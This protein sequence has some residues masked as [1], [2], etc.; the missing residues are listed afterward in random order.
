MESLTVLESD[1]GNTPILDSSNIQVYTTESSQQYMDTID[2]DSDESQTTSTLLFDTSS[3][4]EGIS[5]NNSNN[6]D[7]ARQ[8][9]ALD[10]NEQLSEEKSIAVA[11]SE[12]ELIWKNSGS[13]GNDSLT[14]SPNV[15]FKAELVQNSS[16]GRT[17]LPPGFRTSE[18]AQF[19]PQFQWQ[20]NTTMSFANSKNED[21]FVETQQRLE[22][23]KA[24]V[25]EQFL[26]FQNLIDYQKAL[27]GRDPLSPVPQERFLMKTEE[28]ISERENSSDQEP[29]VEDNLFT[30]S[31]IIIAR[32]L[33]K[34]N[35]NSFEKS[36]CEVLDSSG[37]FAGS[38]VE[39]ISRF[40][41]LMLKGQ[42]RR[43]RLLLLHCLF[44]A[45]ESLSFLKRIID[46]GLIILAKWL[47]DF[48]EN[49]DFQAVHLLLKVL[50][51]LPVT[52]HL[53]EASKL[54]KLVNK[55]V[56]EY[57]NSAIRQLA[58]V[59]VEKWKEIIK[60]EATKATAATA[61]TTMTTKSANLVAKQQSTGK[62]GTNN[63]LSKSIQHSK[64]LKRTTNLTAISQQVKKS[65]NTTGETASLGSSRP[66]PI[67]SGK[68][69]L[70][71][72]SSEF[73]MLLFGSDFSVVS[74]TMS[75]SSASISESKQSSSSSST[76]TSSMEN[77]SLTSTSKPMKTGKLLSS[78]KD[79]AKRQLLQLLDDTPTTE[80]SS[81][82]ANLKPNSKV[83]PMSAD[84]I[85][86]AKF[87]EK[88][89]NK[90]ET[91]S[92]THSVNTEETESSLKKALP[93]A[94]SPLEMALEEE[95]KSEPKPEEIME[96]S[97][98]NSVSS[99]ITPSIRT[100]IS[101]TD[102]M[103]TPVLEAS[104]TPLTIQASSTIEDS[105]VQPT[106]DTGKNAEKSK[107][108]VS[109]APEGQLKLVREYSV[110]MEEGMGIGADSV[111]SLSGDITKKER[112]IL[113]SRRILHSQQRESSTQSL[114]S[115][116]FQQWIP[117]PEILLPENF[118]F[119]RGRES[120]QVQI[121]K[122]RESGEMAS[123]FF[124]N[125]LREIEDTLEPDYDDLK[126]PEIPWSEVSM[127]ISS[128]SSSSS[129]PSISSMLS[130]VSAPSSSL[131]A[132]SA[133]MLQLL[134]SNSLIG[135]NLGD[136]SK[137]MAPNIL[138]FTA[139]APANTGSGLGIDVANLAMLIQQPQQSPINQ[140]P[141]S[142]NFANSSSG[143]YSPSL[144]STSLADMASLFPLPIGIPQ[145]SGSSS[146]PA[147]LQLPL[148]PL[149]MIQNFQTSST[150]GYPM[151]AGPVYG[152]DSSLQQRSIPSPLP[153]DAQRQYRNQSSNMAYYEMSHKNINNKGFD[154]G[155]NSSGFGV[156]N[157]HSEHYAPPPPRTSQ[158][159][160]RSLKS[161]KNI[162]CMF[163]LQ[164]GGC[165]NGNNCP[166]SHDVNFINNAAARTSTSLGSR[167]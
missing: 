73:D 12:N 59:I 53:L 130:S 4:S 123:A 129:P 113:E 39:Q 138:P 75:A 58:M 23:Q 62:S 96:Q 27:T 28:V 102:A 155:G 109:W 132:N 26:K 98:V 48:K 79:K 82:R 84:A 112:E 103:I 46:Q 65:K 24:R 122:R 87:K 150:I 72:S 45:K 121:Q 141:S 44:H 117:P 119:E 136:G 78:E 148:L 68:K 165:R 9:L 153:T 15:H 135:A 94:N 95:Q 1:L 54:G 66:T 47:K 127:P 125:E 144:S 167:V 99:L 124:E 2:G 92:S 159:D 55:I 5:R 37:S 69:Q 71:S 134:L 142:S 52:L 83:K 49:N 10:S 160:R 76:T 22:K 158:G 80:T 51:V 161:R 3:M 34:R 154:N 7:V 18:L 70:L 107:K 126:T 91:S 32:I 162:P 40:V 146:V 89:L 6:D 20:Q 33:E 14:V 17:S 152:I 56:K 128:S 116:S 50:H 133:A 41:Q 104:E 101:M 11:P 63:D 145:S 21:H 85:R 8:F 111:A 157:F 151:N 19:T 74:N 131:P 38:S 108:R 118:V 156:H 42:E 64:N 31:N 140:P 110:E 77:V 61:G 97:D 166:Y 137:S 81:R 114:P 67:S 36:I 35:Q 57:P 164:P 120:K 30:D 139:V 43:E 115:L 93:H 147:G 100:E 105:I 60:K 29:F 90:R 16:F 143:I 13:S 86:K 149:N 106:V 163:Y 88:V 25:A